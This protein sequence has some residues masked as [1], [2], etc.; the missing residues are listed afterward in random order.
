[1]S[2]LRARPS[3]AGRRTWARPPD[4]GC[5]MSPLMNVCHWLFLRAGSALT[6]AGDVA[7]TRRASARR[8]LPCRLLPC[9]LLC[10][11]SLLCG[12]VPGAF[13]QALDAIDT[14]PLGLSAPAHADTV[15]RVAGKPSA[16]Q[17][18]MMGRLDRLERDV[19][20]ANALRPEGTVE[21]ITYR[22]PAGT[23]PLALVDHY[24]RLLEGTLVYRCSGRDCGR[25]SEWANA[26]F[27]SSLLYGPDARQAYAAWVRDG[28]LIAVYS[29]ERG[30]RRVY[31]HL[32]V[33]TPR[34]GESPDVAT[35][36]ALQ[37][38]AQRW[39]VIPGLKPAVDG[40]LTPQALAPMAKLARAL[41]PEPIWVVCHVGGAA[42]PETL[43]T[44]ADG[45]ADTVAASLSEA[46]PELK[47]KAFGVGPLVPRPM[48][49]DSRVELVLPAR[50][51]W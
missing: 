48:T 36:V 6:K 10:V 24:A 28:K 38:R 44:A 26:L 41:G 14:A 22:F 8:L 30:N 47:S 23:D 39:A 29:I 12:A 37:L 27:G 5:S 9:R 45:C 19:R 25:S 40:T 17:T 49:G 18:F 4:M 50:G 46:R 16:V 11:T 35:I 21:A 32:R 3:L 33:I 13:A 43:V 42:L 15:D 34:D 2:N 7:R 1:M 51:R 20:G 31:S